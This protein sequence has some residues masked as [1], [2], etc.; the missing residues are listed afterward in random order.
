[1][2]PDV[3]VVPTPMHTG[4]QMFEARFIRVRRSHKE[5]GIWRIVTIQWRLLTKCE[6]FYHGQRGRRLRDRRS[7]PMAHRSLPGNAGEVAYLV[8]SYVIQYHNSPLAV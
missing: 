8:H 4:Y 5:V 1:A 3:V 2:R 7:E 6:Y